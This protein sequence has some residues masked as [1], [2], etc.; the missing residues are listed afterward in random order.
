[1][2]PNPW[3]VRLGALAAFAIVIFLATSVINLAAS[4]NLYAQP[5]RTGVLMPKVDYVPPKKQVRT[6]NRIQ[7]P[8]KYYRRV[9]FRVP[10]AEIDPMSFV[11][12]TPGVQVRII[13]VNPIKETKHETI[14]KSILL[15][16][17]NSYSMVQPSP[18][19]PWNRDWLPRADPDYQRIDA[20]KALVEVLG[21][22]DRVALA[23]FPRLNP[24]PGYRIPRVEPPAILK[25][26]GPAS[27]VVPSLEQLRGNENS[28]TP[29]YRVLSMA[30]DWMANEQDRPRFIVMLT[31]GRDTESSGGAPEGLRAALE[32]AGIKV[33]IVALGP[34]P[35]LGALNELADELIPVS[36]SNQLAPTFRKLAEKLETFVIGHEVELELIR[37]NKNFSDGEDVSIGYRAGEVP[38]RM[39]VRVGESAGSANATAGGVR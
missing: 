30:V 20:V 18:P 2:L 5:S 3:T 8:E 33:I 1:M 14:D 7:T 12:Y 19:S 31:D 22:R 39:T 4:P 26:F 35:D 38:E 15:L 29:L 37:D 24:S 21:E 27:A 6:E 9:N 32:Q 10:N 28:G 23:T 17:D 13:S 36:A 34:A 16:L 25:D 11:S